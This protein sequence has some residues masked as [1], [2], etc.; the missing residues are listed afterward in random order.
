MASVETRESGSRSRTRGAILQA[1]GKLLVRRRNATLSEIADAASVSRSTLH[2]YFPDRALL[3][4]AVM[5]DSLDELRRATQDAALD[6]GPPLEALRRLVTGY[7]S[8]GVQIRFLFGDPQM[9]VDPAADPTAP[10]PRWT[11]PAETVLNLIK[12]GQAE[13]ALDAEVSADWIE[14]VL[15]GLIYTAVEAVD[16]GQLP[17]HGA[18]AT[19]IRTLERGVVTGTSSRGTV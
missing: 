5:E 12:R 15:W 3:V 6:Q 10:E 16:Q 2:R 4:D 9:W 8:L 1:A 7:A 18:A 13:G 17:R 11:A 19:V 14:R